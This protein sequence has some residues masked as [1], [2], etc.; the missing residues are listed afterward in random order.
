MRTKARK[1]CHDVNSRRHLQPA[2]SHT[3]RQT[4]TEIETE[5]E[6]GRQSEG[7]RERESKSEIQAETTF[8][9]K[10]FRPGK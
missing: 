9:G 10:V 7:E 4:A 6:I 8:V 3:L 1:L 5:T 2:H